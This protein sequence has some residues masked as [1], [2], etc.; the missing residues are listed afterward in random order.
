M[1]DVRY[2]W[3]IKNKCKQ[4]KILKCCGNVAQC[5]GMSCSSHR[6]H[7]A[8]QFLMTIE[9]ERHTINWRNKIKTTTTNTMKTIETVSPSQ[10]M[11]DIISSFHAL[12]ALCLMNCKQCQ[13]KTVFAQKSYRPKR[14]K[15]KRIK[16]ESLQEKQKKI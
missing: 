5:N 1:E 8:I 12:R 7:N 15:K 6:I 13:L 3:H 14:R 10:S 2:E 11:H 9:T 4:Y 16:T